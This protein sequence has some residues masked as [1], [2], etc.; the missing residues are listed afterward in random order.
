MLD[1]KIAKVL[2]IAQKNGYVTNKN[3]REL[4][5]RSPTFYFLIWSLRD[6]GIVK[7]MDLDE[8]RQNMWKLTEKGEKITKHITEI[9]KLMENKI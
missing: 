9:I 8:R 7:I 6:N 4:G 5:I 2:Q 3:C 1:M